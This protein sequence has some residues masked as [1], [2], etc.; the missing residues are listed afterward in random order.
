MLCSGHVFFIFHI[1]IAVVQINLMHHSTYVI[2]LYRL[3]TD[4]NMERGGV[5][6]ERR[7]PN[8][9][10]LVRSPQAAPCCVLEQDTLTPYSMSKPRKRWLCADLTER[11]LI[12]TL[13]LN[14]FFMYRF[15]TDKKTRLSI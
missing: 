5:V 14:S 8:Q 11:L 4:M 13:S 2:F 6:V 9:E 1:F 12:G 7:T 10:V 15:R 3:R